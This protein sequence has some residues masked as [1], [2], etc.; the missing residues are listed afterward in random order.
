MEAEVL[1]F[2]SVLKHI[3]IS[4]LT[5]VQ[6]RADVIGYAEDDPIFAG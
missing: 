5:D 4:I 2:H 6:N 1:P 3:D